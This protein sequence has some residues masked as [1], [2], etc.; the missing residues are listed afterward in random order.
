MKMNAESSK[1][2]LATAGDV[3][4]TLVPFYSVLWKKTFRRVPFPIAGTILLLCLGY[5]VSWMLSVDKELRYADI[6][7]VLGGFAVAFGLWASNRMFVRT[8]TVISEIEY[9]IKRDTTS[10]AVNAKNKI[11]ANFFLLPAGFL[12]GV[13][14]LSLWTHLGLVLSRP[15]SLYLDVWVSMAGF[16]A[17]MGLWQAIS[18][19]FL[20]RAMMPEDEECYFKLAPSRSGFIRK[21]SGLFSE[22]AVLFAIE[23]LP[24]AIGFACFSYSTQ[25]MTGLGKIKANSA[26]LMVSSVIVLF[27]FI[28]I[29]PLYFMLPQLIIR[30]RVKKITAKISKEYQA[31]LNALLSGIG[32]G[33][34]ENDAK[35]F[36]LLK[37]AE[38][39]LSKSGSF[40]LGFVDFAKPFLS[41]APSLGALFAS[42]NMVKILKEV[43]KHVFPWF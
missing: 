20:V 16:V 1:R 13:L 38:V 9:A 42:G 2:A 39:A 36:A 4:P 43:A 37:E 27:I 25:Q 31:R 15:A 6:Y 41:L 11:Y 40:P 33:I 7:A 10:S 12:F 26:T 30:A 5:P 32:K 34:Q 23:V 18:S 8:S 28:I 19:L 35:E 29:M 22:Y 24:F 21:I 14:I 3:P 17:G